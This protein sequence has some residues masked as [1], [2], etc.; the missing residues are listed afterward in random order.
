VTCEPCTSLPGPVVDS[1]PIS[2][3]ATRQLPLW[4]GM[5]TAAKSYGSEQRTGSP[6]CGCTRETSGCSIHPNTRDEWIASMR[7]SLART[8]ATQ[9]VAQA[10]ERKRE[11]A[12]TAKSSASLAWFEPQS[13]SWRTSQQSLVPDCALFSETWPR[14]GMTANGHAYE[15]PTLELDI[16]ETDG[17]YLPTPAASDVKGAVS[18]EATLIQRQAH[19]RGVR[20]EEALFRGLLPTPTVPN[21]HCVGRLDEWGGRNKYR[22]SDIGKLHLNPSFVEELMLW[23]RGWTVSKHWA[24]GKFHCKRPSPGKSSR[25]PTN[26]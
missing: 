24:T 16:S 11:A 6:A 5:P 20:L 1:L 23:P 25:Q 3:S 22:G 8:L 4:S 2:S 13:C 12:S 14:S 15:L 10:L 9:E 7:A 17:G 21:S 26:E 18:T 19:P